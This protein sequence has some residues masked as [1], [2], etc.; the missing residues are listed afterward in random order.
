MKELSCKRHGCLFKDINIIYDCTNL[1]QLKYLVAHYK[2]DR[3]TDSRL[4]LP[5]S[6]N[7][8]K[9]NASNISSSFSWEDIKVMKIWGFFSKQL[10]NQS[11]V[12]SLKS[13]ICTYFAGSWASSVNGKWCESLN[14]SILSFVSRFFH[15]FPPVKTST[16]QARKD[17]HDVKGFQH[18]WLHYC[19]QR[20]FAA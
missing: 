16:L 15:L 18:N 10:S 2:I 12:V 13:N 1:H 17:I 11:S 9:K 7:N 5:L 14:K 19:I 6:T 20:G 3:S 4:L 8:R